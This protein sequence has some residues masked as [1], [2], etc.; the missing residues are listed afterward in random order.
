[1]SFNSL[2]GTG[3]AITEKNSVTVNEDGCQIDIVFRG[4]LQ[5]RVSSV[6][7]R[8]ELFGPIKPLEFDLDG[9]SFF[10][11]SSQS[12]DRLFFEVEKINYIK[13][14]DDEKVI[15]TMAIKIFGTLDGI[16]R[17]N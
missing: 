15:D 17:R 11:K 7:E 4:R 14:S 16:R 13:I 9:S 5:N 10:S 8:D 3:F 1:M 2:T 12:N 6:T